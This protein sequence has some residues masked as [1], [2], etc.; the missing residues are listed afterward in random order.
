MASAVL[1]LLWIQS[2]VSFDQFHQ[3]KDR[4]YEAWNRVK[5]DGTYAC[6][7]VTPMVLAKTLKKDFPEVEHAVRVNWTQ[8]YLFSVGEKRI[9]GDGNIVDS[10]FLELFSFPLLQGDPSRALLEPTSILLT[11]KMARRLFGT[12]DAMGKTITLDNQFT[13]K[14]TGILQDLPPNTRF[15]FDCLVPWSAM[16]QAFG[17]DE[18]WGNNSTATYVLLKEHVQHAS[19]DAK[20]KHLRRTY[21]KEDPDGEMFLY[22]MTRW[23]LYSRFENGIESGGLIEFVRLFGM[24]ALIILLIAC[25]NFMNLSTARSEKRAKEV[26]IRK[27]AGARRGSL[28]GQF[29]G[30]SVLIA[31]LA[32]I[33]ALLIV[34]LALP[35]F[36]QLTERSLEVQYGHWSFWGFFLGFMVFTGLLAGSYSGI[37]RNAFEGQRF[38]N[39]P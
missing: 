38:G 19:V 39:P 6:W 12:E 7:N 11:Q 35:A 22:P 15:N 25:I 37:E 10:N 32:G 24:V 20:I 18:Y 30:E 36:S 9:M 5:R 2:E 16:R 28:V 29:L 26:G 1:I 8:Q 33:L 17:E 27:V 21:D 13:F 14:V 4:V 23:R 3:K 31:C 34:E